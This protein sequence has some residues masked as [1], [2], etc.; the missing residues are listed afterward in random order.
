MSGEAL[1]IEGEEICQRPAP[2][3]GVKSRAMSNCRSLSDPNQPAF[4]EKIAQAIDAYVRLV[5]QT[6]PQQRAQFTFQTLTQGLR[7]LTTADRKWDDA[8]RNNYLANSE[9]YFNALKERVSK[10]DYSDAIW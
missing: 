4:E 7:E 9:A 3:A 1:R 6:T 2:G 10:P 8:G 5:G